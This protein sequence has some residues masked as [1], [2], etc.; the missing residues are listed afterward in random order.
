M[1]DSQLP[2][3][4]TLSTKEQNLELKSEDS[5]PLSPGLKVE[6]VAI[7][8]PVSFDSGDNHI[9]NLNLRNIIYSRKKSSL[10]AHSNLV[11]SKTL[12]ISPLITKL[13]I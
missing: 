7:S 13:Q 4:E 11:I 3:K 12:H 6:I 9:S 5:T 10:I 1:S 8:G 2:F